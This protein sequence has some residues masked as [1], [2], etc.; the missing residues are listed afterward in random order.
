M[1]VKAM[2]TG[3]REKENTLSVI[4]REREREREKGCLERKLRKWKRE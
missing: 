2:K 4:E 3:V 1:N